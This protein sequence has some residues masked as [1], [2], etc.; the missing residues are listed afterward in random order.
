MNLTKKVFEPEQP[1]V[2]K[3]LNYHEA[4]NLS[5]MK[6]RVSPYEKFLVKDTLG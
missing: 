5:K 1:K 2:D 4:E 3:S 6:K